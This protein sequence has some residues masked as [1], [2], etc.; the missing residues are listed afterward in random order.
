GAVVMQTSRAF[1]A[2]HF[3]PG[4]II[5]ILLIRNGNP[6]QYRSILPIDMIVSIG[7]NHFTLSFSWF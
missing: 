5:T 4:S 2:Q 7:C 1:G 6:H 3:S